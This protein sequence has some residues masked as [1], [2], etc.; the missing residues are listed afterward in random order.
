MDF[1]VSLEIK[2]EMKTEVMEKEKNDEEDEAHMEQADKWFVDK[3]F[4]FGK[5]KTSETI[6]IHASVVQWG[7]IAPCRYGRGNAWTKKAK[8]EEQDKEKANAASVTSSSTN[9][10][11]REECD[12]GLHDNGAPSC[13]GQSPAFNRSQHLFP[14][15]TNSPFGFKAG[16]PTHNRGRQHQPDRNKSSCEHLLKR[17]RGCMTREKRRGNSSGARKV[18]ADKLSK[19]TSPRVFANGRRSAK[20]WRY[21]C[22]ATGKAAR[23]RSL[24]VPREARKIEAITEKVWKLSQSIDGRGMNMVQDWDIFLCLVEEHGQHPGRRIWM[25]KK[26]KKRR[27]TVL[28]ETSKR[29][30]SP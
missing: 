10:P 19:L 30:K 22:C 21:L 27:L 16:F 2:V 5:V 4:G 9:R 1:L 25:A 3:G 24:A 14:V 28:T 13:N 12:G 26:F 29:E 11:E 7:R 8:K 15:N 17:W 6:F 23:R 18:N 20:Y